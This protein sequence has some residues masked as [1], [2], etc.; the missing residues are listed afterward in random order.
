[1][2]TITL[3]QAYQILEDCAAV[4]WGSEDFLCV[5]ALLP[6]NE[7]P[8]NEFMYLNGEDS[9]GQE[10]SV[11]FKEGNNQTVKVDGSQLILEDTEGEECLIYILVPA[12]ICDMVIL[13]N[14]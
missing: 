14:S 1:M 11:T 12:K 4:Q 7:D 10:Y 2:K 9:E 6:P 8:E 5:P 13:S 3:Q